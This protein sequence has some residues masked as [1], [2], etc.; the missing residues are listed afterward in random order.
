MIQST[1]LAI[2]LAT[3]PTTQPTSD[4]VRPTPDV[5]SCG[6]W[7]PAP[8]RVVTEDQIQLA[9][10]YLLEK[11]KLIATLAH[12]TL[13]V[14][15]YDGYVDGDAIVL[16]IRYEPS[17]ILG[18]RYTTRIRYRLNSSG[19]SST[20]ILYDDTVFGAFA[21]IEMLKSVAADLLRQS[22][23]EKEQNDEEVSRAARM[24]ES[25]LNSNVSGNEIHRLLL[26]LLWAKDGMIA[27]YQNAG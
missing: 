3:A 19:I 24:L 12:P 16:E 6:S 11:A 22:R 13:V 26:H 20:S 27:R 7:N 15:D 4:P 2:L 8:T 18:R 25:A 10:R 14:D 1:L 21:G 9:G 17:G 23:E 5:P